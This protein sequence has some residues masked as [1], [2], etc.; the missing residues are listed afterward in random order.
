MYKCDP[1]VVLGILFCHKYCWYIFD[2]FCLANELEEK[3][4]T[5][6]QISASYIDRH[7]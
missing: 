3:D 5:D 4:T 1:D 6:I 2:V 7:H